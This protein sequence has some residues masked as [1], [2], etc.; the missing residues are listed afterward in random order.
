[1]LNLSSVNMLLKKLDLII[2]IAPAIMAHHDRDVTFA[3][4]LHE[5]LQKQLTKLLRKLSQQ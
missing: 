1:M 2:V 5:Q 4:K 3:V